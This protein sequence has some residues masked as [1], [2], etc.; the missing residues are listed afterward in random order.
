MNKKEKQAEKYFQQ[1]YAYNNKGDYDKAIE[2]Y[3][4]AIELNPDYA[5]A[6]YNLGNVYNNKGDYGKAIEYYNKAIEYYN[7]AIELNPDS[8]DAYNNLGI[9]YNIKSDDDKA[10]EYYN[11]AIELNPGSIAYTI[12]KML[13]TTKATMT[14]PLNII[15]KPLN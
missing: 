13:I 11:K 2:Y 14:K 15:I 3:N 7:K 4:K 6:Y 1:G 10:I 12:W 8:V 5:V 9:A